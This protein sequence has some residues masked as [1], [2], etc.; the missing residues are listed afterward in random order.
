MGRIFFT[1]DT[2]F[3]HKN[4]IRYE[5]RPYNSVEQMD[6]ALITNWNNVVG[7]RDRVYVLGDFAFRGGKDIIWKLNGKKFLVKGNHDREVDGFEWVK[8]YCYL[9]SNYGHFALFHYP[10][11]SWEGKS[12][13]SIHLHGHTH[14]RTPNNIQAGD[15]I[16]NVG[17]DTNNYRPVS[18]DEILDKLK[19]NRPI[20]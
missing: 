6:R 2:H 12:H 7:P 13:G 8:D 9:K 16:Y 1:A 11:V 19:C 10:I 15:K 20:D 14:S 18:I 17:V 4:I 5:K 3:G